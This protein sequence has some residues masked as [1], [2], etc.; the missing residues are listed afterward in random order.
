[1]N[2][3]KL[4]NDLSPTSAV[5]VARRLTQTNICSHNS[6]SVRQCLHV[7][8]RSAS[9]IQANFHCLLSWYYS[10]VLTDGFLDVWQSHPRHTLIQSIPLHSSLSYPSTHHGDLPTLPSVMSSHFI[11]IIHCALSPRSS[12]YPIKVLIFLCVI[13]VLR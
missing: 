4:P 10:C 12:G 5:A 6:L 11:P 8:Y 9:F 7:G 3:P 2:R 13:D 1:M